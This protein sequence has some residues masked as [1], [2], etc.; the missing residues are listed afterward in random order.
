MRRL[1]EMSLVKKVLAS[2]LLLGVTGLALGAL[3]S[4]SIADFNATTTNPGN[5]FENGTVLMTN[6]AGTVVSGSN[7][8]TGTYSGTCATIFNLTNLKENSSTS[9]NTVTITYTGS[10]Q[11]TSLFGLYVT[12]LGLSSGNQPT[13][14][15]AATPADMID[16][17]ITQG[18]TTIYG[19]LNGTVPDHSGTLAGFAASHSSTL[20]MLS[21]KGGTNGSGTAGAWNTSDSSVFTIYVKLDVL[22]TNAYQGCGVTADFVWYAQQ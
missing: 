11:P 14:C 13:Y 9:T 7:C 17:A 4:T 12:N 10:I 8:T 16:L 2:V 21:L 15:T 20:N 1:R 3:F 19:N 6:V 18:T 5:K 22:A